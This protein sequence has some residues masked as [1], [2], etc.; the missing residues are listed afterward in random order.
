MYANGRLCRPLA[1]QRGDELRGCRGERESR[2]PNPESQI[3]AR[4]VTNRS[5]VI[6]ALF[7]TLVL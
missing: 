4:I 1:F 2:I 7:V 6:P 5:H 3:I